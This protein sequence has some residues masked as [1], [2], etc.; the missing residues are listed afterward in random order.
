MKC[1]KCLKSFNAESQ[2]KI[3]MRTHTNERPFQCDQCGKAFTQKNNLIKHTQIHNEAKFEC[4]ICKKL[5]SA[6]QNLIRHEEVHNT[7]FVVYECKQCSK[8]FVTK[9]G[10]Q[11]HAILH[12]AQFRCDL[13]HKF[14]KDAALYSQHKEQLYLQNKFKDN[15]IEHQYDEQCQNMCCVYQ[16]LTDTYLQFCTA[17]MSDLCNCFK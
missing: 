9:C 3:H 1:T 2:L 16:E 8:Q 10:L 13:C 11:H 4:S 5:F 14:F 6:K 12:K 7:K 17:C 15:Q